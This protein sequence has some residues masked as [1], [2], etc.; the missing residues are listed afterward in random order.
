MSAFEHV[1]ITKLDGVTEVRLHSNGDALEWNAVVHRELGHALLEVG[2][3]DETRVVIITG[4]GPDFCTRI[5]VKSFMRQQSWT[6]VWSEG[7]RF[8]KALLDLDVL[9]I[10]AV[11]GP[12]LIHAEIPLLAD[13]VIAADTTVIADLAHFTHGAVPG[14]GA[15]LVWPYL[16]GPRRGKYFLLTGQR[17]EAQEALALGLVNE[18]VPV[19][20]VNDRALQLAREW[21]SQPLPVIKY[22]RECLNI[23]EREQLMLSTGLSHGLALEGLALADAAAERASRGRPSDG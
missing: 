22:T 20:A 2:A 1:A 9:V 17:I 18:L 15:H 16:L 10:G 6:T 3:D 23:I 7:K 5:D 13:V 21:A 12:A 8:L 19:G 11:N 14:D 4:T